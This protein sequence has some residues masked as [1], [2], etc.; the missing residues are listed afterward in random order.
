MGAGRIRVDGMMEDDGRSISR[1]SRHLD[2]IE[3]PG[4]PQSRRTS[5]FPIGTC[6]E[7]LEKGF[8]GAE[9][10]E[11]DA[12]LDQEGDGAAPACMCVCDITATTI[13]NNHQQPPSGREGV[14]T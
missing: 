7:C 2:L 12:E 14:A 1:S 6:L 10:I 11:T 4:A 3:G 13:S 5:P 8:V 9:F